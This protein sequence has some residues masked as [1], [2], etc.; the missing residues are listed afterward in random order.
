ME[1]KLR[2]SG[3]LETN[4]SVCYINCI[5]ETRWNCF[6]IISKSKL[7]RT[8]QGSLVILYKQNGTDNACLCPLVAL[9][10][11]NYPLTAAQRKLEKRDASFEIW[12]QMKANI[13]WFRNNTH[14]L[15]E[16]FYNSNLMKRRWT[17]EITTIESDLNSVSQP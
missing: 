11:G 15:G 8:F 17:C 14:Q 4:I 10:C 2:I 6:Q 12:N 16:I 7:G 1:T 3:Q 5:S 9:F 13:K